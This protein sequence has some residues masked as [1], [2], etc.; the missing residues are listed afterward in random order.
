MRAVIIYVLYSI[1]GST[2]TDVLFKHLWLKMLNAC[3]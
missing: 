2:V 3:T 1:I